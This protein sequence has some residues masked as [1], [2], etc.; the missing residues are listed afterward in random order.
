M[1]GANVKFFFFFFFI[2][3]LSVKTPHKLKLVTQKKL[4]DFYN[5]SNKIGATYGGAHYTAKKLTQNLT[6]CLNI[7]AIRAGHDHLLQSPTNK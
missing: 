4:Y 6:T 5:C 3:I 1:I 2:K 7:T